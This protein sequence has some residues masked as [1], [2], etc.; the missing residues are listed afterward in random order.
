MPTV[1][2]VALNFNMKSTYL[3]GGQLPP[4]SLSHKTSNV[5]DLVLSDHHV[6]QDYLS[7]ASFTCGSAATIFFTSC[8]RHAFPLLNLLFEL[9]VS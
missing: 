1:G 3:R 4:I 8:L 2:R 9:S 7:C 5:I 6:L